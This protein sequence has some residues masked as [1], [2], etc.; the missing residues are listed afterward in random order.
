MTTVAT[1]ID[2]VGRITDRDEAERIGVAA[3]E[4]LL[5]DLRAM[6]P[7]QWDAPTVCAPWTIADM[8]RHLLGAAKGNVTVRE[9]ARQQIHGARHRAEFAGNALDATNDLQVTEHRHLD[10]AGL[11]A[12]LE[13]VF[14]KS[15]RRR[16]H[17]ARLYNRINVAID[18]GGSTA[19][20]MPD[21]LNLGELFRV[22]YTR[23][24]WLHRV[25]IA[26]ALGRELPLSPDIDGR[27]VQD[28]VKEW[29]DRHGEPFDLRLTGEAG[30]NYRRAGSGPV[31]ELDAVDF[32]WILSGR[33]QPETASPGGS[34]L[35]HR[36]LF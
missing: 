15:V 3:Y 27:I 29:A 21:R 2:T 25:D 32:C 31:I 7:Q 11:L 20:G 10:P 23:D 6:T 30:G 36:V 9:M 17:R 24:V 33:G 26:R 8:A 16:T 22:V 5:A 35:T 13:G 18:A 14:A 12:E 4:A 28:V 1:D 34:L 19:Q